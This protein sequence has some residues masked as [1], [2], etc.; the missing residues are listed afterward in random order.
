MAEYIHQN[1]SVGRWFELSLCEQLGNV[2]SEVGRAAN[3]RRKN[4]GEQSEKAIER[5]MELLDLTIA[6][7]RWAGARRKELCRARELIKDVFYGDNQYHDS[8]EALEKYFFQFAL[9][10]RRNN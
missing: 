5:G 8:P 1:L 7:A 10:A 3:W 6:D 4:Q 9:A 2:G